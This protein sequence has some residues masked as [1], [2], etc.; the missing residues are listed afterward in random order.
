MIDK[1]IQKRRY[2]TIREIDFPYGNGI[3]LFTDEWI[4]YP[5]PKNE[6]YGSNE[7]IVAFNLNKKDNIL[8][9]LKERI[10][11]EEI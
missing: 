7:R 8:Q 11:W 5:Y 1:R 2:L 3:E 9:L 4:E 6:P 10:T